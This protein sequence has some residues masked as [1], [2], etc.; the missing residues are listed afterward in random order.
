MNEVVKPFMSEKPTQSAWESSD[1]KVK[2]HK[3]PFHKIL[4][5]TL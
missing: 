1:L 4:E 5:S 2:Q 3:T